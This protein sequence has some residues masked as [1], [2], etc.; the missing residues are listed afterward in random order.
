M[1]PLSSGSLDSKR[2]N[3]MLRCKMADTKS[4]NRSVPSLR[5]YRNT[6]TDSTSPFTW[7]PTSSSAS[8]SRSAFRMPVL[9]LEWFLNTVCQYLRLHIRSLKSLNLSR[10][11]PVLCRKKTER[12]RRRSDGGIRG[13]VRLGMDEIRKRPKLVARMRRVRPVIFV[14]LNLLLCV[15]RTEWQKYFAGNL[16]NPFQSLDPVHSHETIR[17][18]TTIKNPSIY[19]CLEILIHRIAFKSYVILL[20]RHWVIFK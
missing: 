6:S 2:L 3:A 5:M 16:F 13:R 4:P 19:F 7:K 15:F 14:E 8:L 12:T 20:D 1:L 18:Q 11:P 9:S 17:G 10:P